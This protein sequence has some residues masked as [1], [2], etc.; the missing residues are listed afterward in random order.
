[1]ENKGKTSALGLKIAGMTAIIFI[2]IALFNGILLYYTTSTST[3]R[4][5]AN[6]SM[7]LAGNIA[8]N[9]DAD[10]Y[11]SFLSNK[12]PDKDYWKLRDQLDDFREKTGA[13]YVY[14]LGVTDDD[15]LEILV[16]GQPEGSEDESEIGEVQDVTDLGQVRPVLDGETA[17]TD[18]VKDPTY[19]DYLSS[20]APIRNN[21]GDVI[22]ILAVDTDASQ[23]NAISSNVLKSIL[24][25]IVPIFFVLIIVSLSIL[26]FYILKKLKPLASIE[27]TAKKVADGNLKAASERVEQLPLD[28]K[29]EIGSLS[30]SFQ[31]MVQQLETIVT[32]IQDNAEHVAAASEELYASANQTNDAND[33][34]QEIFQ[35]VAAS[36]DTQLESMDEGVQGV[37]N[38][39]ETAQ[40]IADA[41]MAAT[42][43]STKTVQTAEDGQLTIG[44][45]LEQ[46]ELI[47]QAS[48]STNEV[49]NRLEKH[50]NDIAS[51]LTVIKEIAEQ[52]NLLALN[53]AIEAARAG[54]HG[55]G[56]AVVSEEIR[57]LA[58]QSKA[59]VGKISS[60]INVIQEDMQ[61][62][63]EASVTSGRE[64]NK[65]REVARLAGNSFEHIVEEVKIVTNS[66]EEVSAASEQMAA[67]SEEVTAVI[68][69]M[70]NQAQ[71]TASSANEM[72]TSAKGTAEVIKEMSYASK[73]L[74]D[75]A[76]ELQQMIQRF[77]L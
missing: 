69:S 76:Q 60:V 32:Q 21:N 29:D 4:G 57:V 23:V 43:A 27:E 37:E 67:S 38:I 17:N 62:A 19:G 77:K 64:T 10:A 14:T 26:F 18:I 51:M 36:A 72:T 68:S 47:N 5:I 70:K 12:Q 8:D 55:Q 63:L 15:R 2:L 33:H 35:Q 25:V 9:M 46:M 54:E 48:G 16:D 30:H 11:E 53:A 34:V 52:T 75:I 56:F 41:S 1:M 44:E 31:Y 61:K 74:S 39:S 59:S 40:Q 7:D 71:H 42:D 66:I 20:F 49:I 6:F 28:Q 65:G 22:G 50:S 58:D 3:E 73:G 24:P 13:L 45:V